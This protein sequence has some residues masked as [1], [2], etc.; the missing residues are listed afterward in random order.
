[1][2]IAIGLLLGFVIGVLCRYAALPL[3]A[4][5]ALSGAILVLAMTSGY[6]LTGRVA[7]GRPNLTKALCGGPTGKL[8]S[9]E[10]QEGI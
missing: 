1:M 6:I 2:K 7:Q 9:A 8:P 3:P 10:Q 5:V 4:P